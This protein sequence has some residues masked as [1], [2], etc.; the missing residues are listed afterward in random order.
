MKMLVAAVGTVAPP[1]RIDKKHQ[2]ASFTLAVDADRFIL[3]IPWYAVR[4][5]Y[6]SCN[7]GSR[8]LFNHNTQPGSGNGNQNDMD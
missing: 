1:I 4:T 5:A 3:G 2:S 6:A 7:P 8:R